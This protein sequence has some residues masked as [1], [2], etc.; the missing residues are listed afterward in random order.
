MAHQTVVLAVRVL[1]LSFINF[2]S[3]FFPFR[4]SNGFRKRQGNNSDTSGTVKNRVVYHRQEIL[5]GHIQSRVYVEINQINW[6][7]GLKPL[8]N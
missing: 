3:L 2:I 1:L 5:I 6:L 8:R 7:K 4:H